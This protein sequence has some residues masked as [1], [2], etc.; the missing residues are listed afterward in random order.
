MPAIIAQLSH[1]RRLLPHF[2]PS[3][4]ILLTQACP[5]DTTWNATERLV[6]A[7]QVVAIS[8]ADAHNSERSGIHPLHIQTLQPRFISRRFSL[9]CG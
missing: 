8:I 9:V 3:M 4:A 2:L 1:P 7:F 5:S 6:V